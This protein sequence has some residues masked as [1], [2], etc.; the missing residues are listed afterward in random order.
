M[1]AHT[2]ATAP[3]F[4]I[5]PTNIAVNESIGEVEF[6]VSTDS[7]LSREVVVTAMTQTSDGAP[8][9]ATGGWVSVT[10]RKFSYLSLRLKYECIIMTSNITTLIIFLKIAIINST[11]SA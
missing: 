8:S 7:P 6:F 10:L 1:F 11:N 3:R 5:T 4:T 2:V 9:Q